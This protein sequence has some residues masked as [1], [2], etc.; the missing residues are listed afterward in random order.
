MFPNAPDKYRKVN[1]EMD[2]ELVWYRTEIEKRFNKSEL[3][4]FLIAD[5]IIAKA[6]AG[7]EQ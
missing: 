6:A 3:K 4:N 5:N 7:V 2:K 1:A